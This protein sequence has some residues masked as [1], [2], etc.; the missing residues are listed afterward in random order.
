MD[1]DGRM[2][3]TIVAISSSVAIMGTIAW[4]YIERL[5]IRQGANPKQLGS[6]DERLARMENAIDAMSLEVE[7]I[8][9][10]QRFTTKLLTDRSADA[11]HDSV[12][13]LRP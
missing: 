4:A 5:K 6:I 11:E 3:V 13:E 10:G 1:P 12:R 8:S 7:R 2:V 9:E